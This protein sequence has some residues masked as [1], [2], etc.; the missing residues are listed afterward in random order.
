MYIFISLV[1]A[2]IGTRDFLVGLAGLL[3]GALREVLEIVLARV[4]L[5]RVDFRLVNSLEVLVA[6]P[7][8]LSIVLSLLLPP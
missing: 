4:A 1:V 6:L 3:V 8:P 5:L 7:F 2:F